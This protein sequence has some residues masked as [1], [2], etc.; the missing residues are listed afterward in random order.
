MV[1]YKE[2]F[3]YDALEDLRVAFEKNPDDLKLAQQ[4]GKAELDAGNYQQAVEKFS[5]ILKNDPELKG[6]LKLRAQA[7]EGLTQYIAAINDYKAILKMKPNDL[8]TM[9]AIAT[10]YKFMNKFA[11]GQYWVKKSIVANS[12]SGLPHIVMAEIYEAAV[13]YSQQVENRGR[14]LDDGLVYERA[15]AEYQTAAK[16]PGYTTYANQRIKLL[17]P[18]KPTKEEI[19]FAQGN[20]KLKYESYTSWIEQ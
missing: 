8:E 16:D 1:F 11:E 6:I 4:L 14:K 10:D 18:L 15:I 2:H 9:C 17:E 7:Y 19:F 13:P 5:I 12:K 20:T 3:G